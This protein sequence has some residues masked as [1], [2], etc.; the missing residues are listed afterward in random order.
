[1]NEMVSKFAAA[2]LPADAKRYQN[3]VQEF[4]GY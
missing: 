4:T 2:D 3:F 1:V